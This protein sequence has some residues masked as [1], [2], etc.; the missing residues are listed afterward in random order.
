MRDVV[1]RLLAAGAVGL[2]VAG[3]AYICAYYDQRGHL[4]YR[5]LEW[6]TQHE[7]DSLQEAIEKHRRA[8]GHLPADLAEL[9][10]VKGQRRFRVDADGR[11]VDVW[12]HPYQYRVEGDGYTLYSFGWDG[13]PGGAGR[14]ADIYPTSAGRP[15]ELP[16]LRQFTFDLPTRGVQLTCFLAGVC[17]GLICLLPPRH[18]RRT[19][20]LA[21]VGATV[22][23]A[24]LTAVVISY[25]HIPTGH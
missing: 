10:E 5:F 1:A 18:R 15:A 21:R 8:T 4:N 14:D 25:L 3:T 9:D 7:L 6:D 17:A 16:T 2:V 11:V 23:G 24:I 22:V 20:F 13:R 12:K 19:A